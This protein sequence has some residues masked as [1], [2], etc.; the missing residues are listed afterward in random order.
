[1]KKP[2]FIPEF[3][4]IPTPRVKMPELPLEKREGNFDEVELGLTQ[5]LAR[6][7]AARCLSCRRC[8]GCGLCLA[9][10]DPQAIVYDQAPEERRQRFDAVLLAAGSSCF[11]ATGKPALAYAA[12]PNVVTTV[13]LERMLSPTGPYGGLA[14]RPGDGTPPRRVAFV[15]C[16]GSREEGIGANYCSTTCCNTALGLADELVRAAGAAGV[17]FF[18]RGMRP[19][20]RRGESLYRQA[21]DDDRVEFVFGE[22]SAVA[23]GECTDPVTVKYDAG[24]GEEAAEF[25]LVVLSIGTQASSAARSIARRVRAP[26]N[27]FG[28]VATDLLHPIPVG[29]EDVPV[30]GG[31]A[32]PTDAAGA[33][34]A[35]QAAASAVAGA[36]G[37]APGRAA[38]RPPAGERPGN[39]RAAVWVCAYGL[40]AGGPAAEGVA[41]AAASLDGVAAA[42]WSDLACAPR[43]VAAIARAVSDEG[44]GRV[45]IVGCHPGTHDRFWL[46]KASR[47]AD[48]PVSVELVEG[49]SDGAAAAKDV[50]AHLARGPVRDAPAAPAGR[51]R[52]LL[53]VGGGTSG[54]AAAD[55]ASRR[56]VPVTL[57]VGD[58]ALGGRHAGRISLTEGLTEGLEA[59]AE[60]VR[61]D[62]SIDVLLESTVAGVADDPAGFVTTV[63]GPRGSAS[64]RHGA[65]VIATGGHDYDP[66][67]EIDGGKGRVITQ[68]E[69]ARALTESALDATEIV[70]IQCVGS[71][72]PERPYCSRVCCAE[73][74]TNVL[75]IREQSPDAAVT[76]LHRG[77]RVW[78]FD[79]ELFA[80]AVDLGVRF[81]EV[82]SEPRVSTDGSLEVSAVE[83]DGGGRVTLTPDLVV[84]STGVVPSAENAPLAR[85]L[86][87][88]VDGDG[89]LVP[90][91]EGLRPV[92][93]ARPAVFVCGTACWPASVREAAAQARAAAGKACLFLTGGRY[94]AR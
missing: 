22:V 83:A 73:A 60:R 72:S 53:V 9:E 76:V 62:A 50:K 40:G 65:I 49:S 86:G 56:G 37:V 85:V 19:F 88:P 69:L 63:R 4:D 61:S 75:R 39:A 16:V 24:Q 2:K 12:S 43:E 5:E 35:A 47:L 82:E 18:H 10:C 15:Q 44:V 32:G 41:S 64:I 71:R 81:V 23:A 38:A 31:L 91:D 77:I 13:E 20:G 89:F 66:S 34:C 78:G 1:L 80:D 74:M 46:G 30:A 48:R 87:I 33:A 57:V 26:F 36:L 3:D 94:D 7:E 11:D 45:L 58:A 67:G 84:L 8:I 17:T 93:T 52:R 59:L 28:F 14:L 92:E 51:E 21:R 27:K 79:E 6:A 90:A 55:E 29:V 68:S 54:L 70:V 25:D 42:G